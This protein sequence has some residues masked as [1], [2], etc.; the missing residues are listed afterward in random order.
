MLTDC[1]NIIHGIIEFLVWFV[2]GLLI[3]A[4]KDWCDVRRPQVAMHRH[5]HIFSS[6]L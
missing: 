5:C 6:L 3:K 1:L 4:E 2:M